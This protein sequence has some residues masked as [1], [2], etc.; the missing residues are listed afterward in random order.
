VAGGVVFIPWYATGFRG[1]GLAEALAEI[2]PMAMRYDATSYGL[3]RSRDDRYRFTQTATFDDHDDWE[4]YWYGEEFSR[5]RAQHHGW[6]Q[7]PV[8][9]VWHD[10]VAAGALAPERAE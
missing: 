6:F 7:V 2:A 3:Y 4:R 9:Y 1:D 5:F 8:L 10:Q